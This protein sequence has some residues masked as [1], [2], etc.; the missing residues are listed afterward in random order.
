MAKGGNGPALRL[1]VKRKDGTQLV[2]KDRDGNSIKLPRVEVLVA[3]DNEGGRF[4]VKF[5][6]PRA[7]A[8]LEK[9]YGGE[10]YFDLYDNRQDEPRGKGKAAADDEDFD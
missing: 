3:W 5:S 7:Q 10:C 6:D 2:A 8:A 4:G 1:K 9:V